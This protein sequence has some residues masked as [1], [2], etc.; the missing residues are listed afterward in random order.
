MRVE[1]WIMD[2]SILPS[3]VT[4]SIQVTTYFSSILAT[5]VEYLYVTYYI[6]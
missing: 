6:R 2:I 1:L 3:Y 5:L 4:S